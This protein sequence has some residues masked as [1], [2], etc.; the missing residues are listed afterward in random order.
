MI[1]WNEQF[2]DKTIKK[3]GIIAFIFI[4]SVIVIGLY[5]SKIKRVGPLEFDTNSDSARSFNKNDT[6][7]N[8]EINVDKNNGT[9]IG[10]QNN[11]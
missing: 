1:N 10:T 3:L 7:S 4:I 9:I 2:K 6:I 11:K 5:E 8:T